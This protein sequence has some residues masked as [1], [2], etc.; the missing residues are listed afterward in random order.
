MVGS[1]LDAERR[2]SELA[3]T[4]EGKVEGRK[5]E[6]EGRLLKKEKEGKPA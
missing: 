1:H 6:I 5:K 4:A 2:K 3:S